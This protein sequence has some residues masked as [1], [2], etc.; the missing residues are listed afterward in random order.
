[1]KATAFVCASAA[2]FAAWL[3]ITY[4][5]DVSPKD[6]PTLGKGS[7]PVSAQRQAPASRDSAMISLGEER[8]APV[9]ARQ[10]AVADESKLAH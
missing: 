9:A 4:V 3:T 1:M 5:R 10:E 8:E 7:V 2:L 6:Y